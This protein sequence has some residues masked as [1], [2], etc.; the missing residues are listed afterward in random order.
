MTDFDWKLR[1]T[2]LYL[3]RRI[4]PVRFCTLRFLDELANDSPDL[5][6][7]TALNAMKDA[8]R[9]YYADLSRYES[10]ALAVDSLFDLLPPEQLRLCVGRTR[11]AALKLLAE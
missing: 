5:A 11:V 8:R 2:E 10:W 7:A 1:A 4:K 9:H 6:L 3:G